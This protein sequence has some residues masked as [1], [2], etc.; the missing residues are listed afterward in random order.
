MTGMAWLPIMHQVS[1]PPFGPDRQRVL[2]ENLVM[3]QHRV[4]EIIHARGLRQR[5]QRIFRAERVP[6]RHFGVIIITFGL[7][8]FAVRPAKL[9][10]HVAQQRRRDHRVIE[11]GVKCL[12]EIRVR[13][14]G[15]EY[16]QRLVPCFARGFGHGVKI[17]VRNFRVQ[18]LSRAFDADRGQTDTDENLLAGFGFEIEVAFGFLA[19]GWIC[20]PHPCPLAPRQR[21]QTAAKIP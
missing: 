3:L 12:L 21:S 17:P 18:I 9:A 11:R 5:Q 4:D 19:G 20:R 2:A 13:R 1:L 16:A 15:I 6:Q 10:V 14:F 8:H 7:M